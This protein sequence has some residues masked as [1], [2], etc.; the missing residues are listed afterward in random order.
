MRAMI[1]GYIALTKTRASTS[2]SPNEGN[3]GNEKLSL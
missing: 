3:E 2:D 1:L